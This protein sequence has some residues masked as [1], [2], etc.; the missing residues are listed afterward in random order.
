VVLS[1]A[2]LEARIASNVAQIGEG[3]LARTLVTLPSH[4]GDG[5]IGN[6]LTPLLCG[7]IIVLPPARVAAPAGI[8]LAKDLGRIIDRH[9]IGFLTSVPG[10]CRMAL[11]FGAPPQD[12]TLK[13]MQIGS[14][15]LSARLWAEV[16]AWARCETLNCYGMTETANWF[17]GAS[18]RAGI[19]EGLLGA[20][21]EGGEA[22]RDDAGAIGAKGDSGQSAA[23]MSCYLDRPD[24]T[25][26][27]LQ[28]GWYRTGDRGKIDTAG[29]IWLTGRIKD[30]INRAGSFTP[31]PPSAW[32]F[33]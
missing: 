29:R 15:P 4:F 28:D 9:R 25:A 16:A 10:L 19:A 8:A 32:V 11:K 6:A 13:R 20:P 31:R 33:S 14:A 5:L 7:G 1:F 30:E 27:A 24:L 2:A 22:V 17:A 21:W 3:A 18:S 26:A 23:L 12:T